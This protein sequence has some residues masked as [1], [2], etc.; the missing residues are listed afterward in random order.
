[1]FL[2]GFPL[3]ALYR[4]CCLSIYDRRKAETNFE[5]SFAPEASLHENLSIFFSLFHEIKAN[6]IA[7]RYLH[8]LHEYTRSRL[9]I[10]QT[11]CAY[12]IPQCNVFRSTSENRDD[13]FPL[14]ERDLCWWDN[15]V[16]SIWVYFITRLLYKLT[17]DPT[18]RLTLRLNSNILCIKDWSFNDLLSANHILFYWISLIL[19]EKE[20]N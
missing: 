3:S 13:M 1:L 18:N 4:R 11:F 5:R 9:K 17:V 7:R 8:R 14:R 6:K 15:Y 12:L 19:I 16:Y 2:R 10:A 20:N